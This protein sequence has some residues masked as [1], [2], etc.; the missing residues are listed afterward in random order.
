M[1]VQILL[2]LNGHQL[3]MTVS[4]I[5][6]PQENVVGVLVEFKI[7]LQYF[8][9]CFQR[10]DAKNGFIQI[11]MYFFVIATCVNVSCFDSVVRNDRFLNRF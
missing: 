10:E 8:F 7:C 2:F 11:N 1:S 9:N 3:V 4:I 5:S 6:Y